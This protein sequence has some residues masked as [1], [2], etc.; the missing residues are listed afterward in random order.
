MTL[1]LEQAA[2]ENARAVITALANKID[3]SG[4]SPVHF[5]R[6]AHLLRFHQDGKAV[7][8]NLS[9]LAILGEVYRLAHGYWYPCSTRC[10][11]LGPVLLVASA[12]PN[13]DLS[14]SLGP[15]IRMGGLMRIVDS[16]PPTFL[17]QSFESW[18]Q[19]PKS[20]RVWTHHN[21]SVARDN[22]RP[23]SIDTGTV[24][25]HVSASDSRGRQVQAGWLRLSELPE[26]FEKTLTSP[27]SEPREPFIDILSR[28]AG[29]RVWKR[30]AAIDPKDV[31]RLRF[32]LD[33]IAG[34]RLSVPVR[35]TRESYTFDLRRRLPTEERVLD[36]LTAQ[37]RT[38]NFRI[39]Y[40][41]EMN[42]L[43]LISSLLAAIGID[44]E[45][46]Q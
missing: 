39:S 9:R 12:L 1:S 23:T 45:I 29:S 18:T 21:M 11:S 19:A 32:G 20:T 34:R 3:E 6:I 38:D 35:V 41:C 5:H 37:S 7:L 27:A 2:V 14:L 42:L 17:A 15:G 31:R 8:E 28:N 43:K 46:R 40:T 25:I 44:L 22:M 4:S 16:A 10:I 24:D 36:G 13:N 26:S 30:E 33:L